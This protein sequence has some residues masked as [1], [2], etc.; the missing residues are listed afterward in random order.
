MGF[1]GNYLVRLLCA[2]ESEG[3]KKEGSG[4]QFTIVSADDGKYVV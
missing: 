2:Q 4:P 1:Y 3:E